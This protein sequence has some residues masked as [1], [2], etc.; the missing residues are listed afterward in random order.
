MAKITEVLAQQT[1]GNKKVRNEYG[2][3]MIVELMTKGQVPKKDQPK[4]AEAVKKFLAE[5]GMPEGSN[6]LRLQVKVLKS[7]DPNVADGSVMTAIIGKDAPAEKTLKNLLVMSGAQTGNRIVLQGAKKVGEE[8]EARWL[9]NAPADRRELIAGL[10]T[11]PTINF[12]SGGKGH[13]LNLGNVGGYNPSEESLKYL[14]MTMQ[15]LGKAVGDPASALSIRVHKTMYFPENAQVLESN[16]TDAL[17]KKI[18]AMS[19]AG[20]LGSAY[21]LR[22]YSSAGAVSLSGYCAQVKTPE[23]DYVPEEIGASLDR[24]LSSIGGRAESLKKLEAIEAAGNVRIEIIPGKQLTMIHGKELEIS[25]TLK[26]AKDL[27]TRYNDAN[28]VDHKKFLAYTASQYGLKHEI[29]LGLPE[30][31]FYVETVAGANGRYAGLDQV[32]TANYAPSSSQ[33]PVASAEVAA[34]LATAPEEE[35]EEDAFAGV[36]I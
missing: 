17:R 24:T 22:I 8:V 31:P 7:F 20:E 12:S 1:A 10:A 27:V 4:M 35:P 13:F 21:A 6:G 19:N 32:P 2:T 9:Y 14:D 3:G 30:S 16:D 23:G 34:P 25:S 18:E 5:N 15:E 36:K 26:Y 29:G 28:D 33:S 11:A